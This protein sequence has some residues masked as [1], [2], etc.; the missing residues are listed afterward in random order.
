MVV[1]AIFN[2]G[3]RKSEINTVLF[4][5]GEDEGGAGCYCHVAAAGCAET[6]GVDFAVL[7][8]DGPVAFADFYGL[9]VVA[10]VE[11]ELDFLPAI[12]VGVVL[13]GVADEVGLIDLVEYDVLG[14]L[15]GCAHAERGMLLAQ[16]YQLLVVV[17]L[18]GVCVLLRPVD[19]ID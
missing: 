9:G 11:H 12:A 2:R 16:F 18:V 15:L 4:R 3:V 6:V 8:H 19:G 5:A 14:N 7:G 1:A 10:A 17:E 13:D